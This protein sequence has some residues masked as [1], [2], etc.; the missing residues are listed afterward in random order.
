MRIKILLCCVGLI[1]IL[2]SGV[3]TTLASEVRGVVLDPNGS[4]IK[5]A[6]VTL[7][8][9]TQGYS[10]VDK[11]NDNGEFLFIGIASGEYVVK[12]EAQGFVTAEKAVR[13][14]SGSSP[15]IR[16]QLEIAALKENV[17]VTPNAEEVGAVTPA[18][19]TLISKEQIKTTPGAARS[20]S[21]RVITSYVPGSY[22]VHNILHVHGGHQVTWL[23]DSVPIPNT[24]TGVD[25]GTPF[26]IND[27]DYL[28]AQRGSYSVE[29]GD[30]TYGLFSIVPRTG[31]GSNR[32]GELALIYGNFN[33]T[34]NFIS[35]A[36]HTKRFA[37]YTS[38]HGF[39]TDYGLA[40]P[41]P[42]VLHDKASG[43]GGF[44]NLIFSPSRAN[45]FRFNTSFERDNYQVPNDR[46]A[47]D[48]G[49]RDKAK[50]RDA[51]V[52]LTWV[53]TGGPHFVFTVSPFY[54]FTA[55]QFVGGPEDKPLIPRHERSS[56][57]GGLHAV[58]TTATSRHS[59]KIGFYGFFERDNNFFGLRSADDQFDLNQRLKTNGNMEAF[60][61]GDQY[62]PAEWLSI[63]GG[64][65]AT[66]FK[67]GLSENALDPRIGATI[68]LPRMNWVLHGF[69]G[70]Y[71]QEPP[72]STVS[73]S[74]L[75]FVETSGFAVLPLHG[76]R[77]EEHQFGITIPYKQWW[78]DAEYYNTKARNFLDHEALGAS[79]IFFPVTIGNAHIRGVDVSLTSPRLF[80]RLRFSLI[81]ARMR[82]EGWGGI[83]GGLTEDV[84]VIKPGGVQVLHHADPEVATGRFFLDHDQR[85]TMTLGSFLSLPWD[86][87]IFGELHYGSG[88][89]NLGEEENEDTSTA[90]HLPGHVRLD[91]GGGK[92]FG[93]KWAVTVNALNVTNGSYLLDN[94]PLLGGVHWVE[95]RQIWAELRY[96][97]RY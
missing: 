77:D 47:E 72:L 13:I 63:T 81:Y 57:Y 45:Q 8:P 15:E 73:G 90:T 22:M 4:P 35:F 16:F 46:E 27:I 26:Y 18:P 43:I 54:H 86:S 34:D 21:A 29:Y 55:G 2:V 75:E 24:N 80:K 67:G 17:Q 48:A 1:M 53:H 30:R 36:D 51:F 38:L 37:Y 65:R 49:I 60:F 58:A 82:A 95:P 12:V 9:K 56:H 20:G 78:F 79:N 28:E 5:A 44:A 32:Q 92:R 87:Y 62:R 93:K 88:F 50:Q 91:L 61:V 68:R 40:T 84:D 42:E 70:R 11:T 94:S 74:L 97:F 25:V 14:V 52:F 85:H 7:S 69:Y 19:T 10:Q 59:L 39:R 41:G 71:Y 3:K 6:Q 64:V 83:S 23:V 96:S 66:H 89:P 33:L 31:F 76:E